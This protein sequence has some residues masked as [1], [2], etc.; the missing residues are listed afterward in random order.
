MRPRTSWTGAQRP[1]SISAIPRMAFIASSSSGETRNCEK[2]GRCTP[3]VMVVSFIMARIIP[4]M[5]DSVRGVRCGAFDGCAGAGWIGRLRRA[6]GLRRDRLERYGTD[7]AA[8]RSMIRNGCD[9]FD[10]RAWRGRDGAGRRACGHA[11]GWR[12][13]RR[14][15]FTRRLCD[16]GRHAACGWL[17]QG[18][19]R[20]RE[21]A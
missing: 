14:G 1:D 2:V 19:R 16:S 20:D 11:A 21:T 12:G 8:A 13:K 9:A 3:T 5:G 10:D 6:D 15:A 7:R 4:Q 17:A 18:T